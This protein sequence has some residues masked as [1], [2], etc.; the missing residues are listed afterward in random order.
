MASRVSTLPAGCA[1]E[2]MRRPI[3]ADYPEPF[4]HI[5]LELARERG[6]PEGSHHDGYDLVVP[7]A[8]APCALT[9]RFIFSFIEVR[10]NVHT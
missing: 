2:T 5:R 7:L 10:T 8:C 6:H 3:A 4:R 1:P 9:H